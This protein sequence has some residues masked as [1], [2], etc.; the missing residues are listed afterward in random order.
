MTLTGSVHRSLPTNQ[1]FSLGTEMN[2]LPSPRENHCGSAPGTA[3]GGFR[4]ARRTQWLPGLAN[5]EPIGWVLPARIL[6]A[7]HSALGR[8]ISK[9][10]SRKRA[11]APG[12]GGTLS[13]SCTSSASSESLPTLS[14]VL[15]SVPQRY[16]SALWCQEFRSAEPP[17]H[18]VATCPTGHLLGTHV[19]EPLHFSCW[20]QLAGN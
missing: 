16:G 18:G 19:P 4:T 8:L 12:Q 13:H 14:T 9:G 2:Y 3:P 1:R 17:C 7:S 11:S 5:A 6:G 20:A 10:T 15:G